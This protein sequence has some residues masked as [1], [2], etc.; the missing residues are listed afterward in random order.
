MNACTTELI[1]GSPFEYGWTTTDDGIELLEEYMTAL[2]MIDGLV[3]DC[4]ERSVAR[5]NVH[6]VTGMSCIELCL[7]ESDEQKCHN[8]KT[9]IREFSLRSG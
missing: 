9:F 8:S 6:A 7:C 2:E 5:M 3:C 4:K 1:A